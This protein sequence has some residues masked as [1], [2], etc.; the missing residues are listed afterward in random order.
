MALSADTALVAQQ[1]FEYHSYALSTS[2]SLSNGASLI[3]PYTAGT[4][5][6][7]T[8]HYTYDG[9]QSPGVEVSLSFD[10]KKADGLGIPLPAGTVRL[11][12]P[13]KDGTLFLGEDAIDHTPV[14]QTLSLTIGSAFDLTGTRTQVSREKVSSS[15]YRETFKITLKNAKDTAVAIDVLEHPSGTWKV[16][17]ST[18]SYTQVN[19]NTIRF[20]LEVP[21]HG[22]KDVT[23]TVEYS[24]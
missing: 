18:Q 11:F 23:Y 1:A 19:A 9:A 16:L 21:A 5:I 14:D 20:T 15:I 22:E 24:Y 12:Q 6:P 13:G 8:K 2:L 3:V 17:S 4:G 7:V 10:N